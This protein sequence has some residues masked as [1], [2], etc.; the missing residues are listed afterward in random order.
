[1]ATSHVDDGLHACCEPWEYLILLGPNPATRAVI[2]GFLFWCGLWRSAF[3]VCLPC[4]RASCKSLRLS[5]QL[6]HCQR[7]REA[8]QRSLPS[9]PSPSQ[10]RRPS[11]VCW[12]WRCPRPPPLP[13][14]MWSASSCGCRCAAACAPLCPPLPCS[15][16]KLPFV[17]LLSFPLSPARELF[18]H[19]TALTNVCHALSYLRL[20]L[21]SPAFARLVALAAMACV[22]LLAMAFAWIGISGYR[23]RF[24]APWARNVSVAAAV[25]VARGCAGAVNLCTSFKSTNGNGRI[26]EPLPAPDPPAALPILH[27]HILWIPVHTSACLRRLSFRVHGHLA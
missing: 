26:A 14:G 24:V 11:G 19:S 20:Q 23:E 1:M 22:T 6:R 7:R 16:F 2:Q 17:Q 18:W 13:C 8:A 4:T 21:P 15:H 9:R 10:S 3:S 25:F 27:P 5:K 12:L